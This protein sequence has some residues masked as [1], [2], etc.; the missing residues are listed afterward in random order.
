MF[1]RET[2][3]RNQKTNTIYVKYQL[4]ESYRTEAGPRQRV[5][6]ELGSGITLSKQDR[7]ELAAILKERLCGQ[8]SVFSEQSPTLSHIADEA[9]RQYAFLQYQSESAT[10]ENREYVSV[11]LQ[12]LGFM[13]QRSL[14]PDLVGNAFWNKL[15][16]DEILAGCGFSGRERALAQAVVVGR[17]VAPAS[18]LA[19]IHWLKERCALIELLKDDLSEVGKDAV[20]E[21]A[22]KIW[23]NKDR[24]ELF[25]KTQE[26]ALF[27]GRTSLF[28]YDVTNT[29]FEGACLGNELA[30]RGHSKD[31]RN[32]CPWVALALVID[33]DG[34][35]IT[36]RIYEGNKSEPQTLEE[37]LENVYPQTEQ[38]SLFLPT[39]V[40]DRGIATKDNVA[41][42]KEK[43]YPFLLIERRNAEKD[44]VSQF[45]HAR[46]NFEEIKDEEEKAKVY[47]KKLDTQEGSRVLCLSQGR[48]KKET[49]IDELKEKRFLEDL[50]RLEKSVAKGNIKLKDKVFERIGRLRERYPRIAPHYDIFVDL[51]NGHDIKDEQHSIEG[52]KSN[53]GKLV[54]QDKQNTKSRSNKGVKVIEVRH[55]KKETRE[56][57]QTLS[58][59]YVIDTSHK[60]LSAQEIWQLYMT[61]TKVE[62]SFRSLKTE[63]GL[64]PIFH[65][66]ADRTKAHLFI[67]VLAYHLLTLQRSKKSAGHFLKSMLSW[68][69]DYG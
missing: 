67:S 15:D 39:I 47:V 64:R 18:D 14:G 49:A 34:F 38:G 1:I 16:F 50:E 66:K 58:G 19:T 35:P 12:S 59:C 46:E 37:I 32:D 63:L 43:G 54:N 5:L 55:E 61:L 10:C 27:P 42:L 7:R 51:E 31:K 29:Y 6:M 48:E 62:D 28:L 24:I 26:E 40:M 53:Q 17:L 68:K 13:Q 69:W 23:D 25:L 33:K 2:K 30:Q 56:K 44:Y 9:M 45:E 8:S 20:Y 3:T 22:D 57:K 36:S 11:D 65:Q 41:L 60:D 21:I 4:V 52:N